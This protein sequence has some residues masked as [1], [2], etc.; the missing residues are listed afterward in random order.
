M[1]RTTQTY[2]ASYYDFESEKKSGR[3]EESSPDTVDGIASYC[4]NAVPCFSPRFPLRLFVRYA[5]MPTDCN[6]LFHGRRRAAS[7]TCLWLWNNHWHLGGSEKRGSSGRWGTIGGRCGGLPT[8]GHQVGDRGP[9]DGRPRCLLHKVHGALQGP[10]RDSLPECGIRCKP[11][12]LITEGVGGYPGSVEPA[13]EMPTSNDWRPVAHLWFKWLV[14]CGS[15]VAQV[16]RNVWLTLLEPLY[17][18]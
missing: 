16:T 7:S 1:Y 15:P 17:Y 4:T 14:T 3:S 8:A 13:S 6:I 10:V 5:L 12:W 11:I 18:D 9:N 2:Y